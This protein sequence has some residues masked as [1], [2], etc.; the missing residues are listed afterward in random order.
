MHEE[1]ADNN[2]DLL[3]M[4]R[5]LISGPLGNYESYSFSTSIAI[6]PLIA[7]AMPLLSAT[8]EIQR[9]S[10]IKNPEF[11]LDTLIHEVRAFENKA[12]KNGYRSQFILGARYLLCA[13][14][15]ECVM[16]YHP[17]AS[18]KKH[19][20]LQIF[21]HD[22][23]GGERFFIILERSCEDPSLYIDLLELGYVALS[24]GFRGK[25]QHASDAKNLGLFIDRLYQV[26]Q[27]Q[28]GDSTH[29]LLACSDTIIQ[30]K[31]LH[32]PPWWALV[33]GTAVILSSIFIPYTRELNQS[34]TPLLYNIDHYEK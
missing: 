31:R 13:L 34:L 8:S 24:L 12:A 33:L 11:F 18:W 16:I 3:D 7:A 29:H 27:K 9:I 25:Y 23:W 2:L 5:E 15:D 32:L 10:D 28:R 4:S 26:I 19:N 17:K 22:V 1:V 14:I 6:N 30:K 21:Q 20:L